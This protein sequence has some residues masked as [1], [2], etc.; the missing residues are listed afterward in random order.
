MLVVDTPSAL[1]S[2][3]GALLGSS[4]WLLIDQKM[5][6]LFAEATGDHQW[7]HVDTARASREMAGGKTVAHG[8]LLISL[9]PRLMIGV[10]KIERRTR[11]LNYGLN[12]VR[13]VS[14]VA[15]GS[16]VRL[17]VTLQK[18]EEVASGLRCIFN[19]QL[20]LEGAAKPAMVA[21]TVTIS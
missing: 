10:L 9:I 2:H 3:V 11:A 1:K 19:N 16:R 15:C 17:I 8:Y 4:D 14:P 7:I 12:K 21:E 13:F 6:D 18:A 5:I 20:D